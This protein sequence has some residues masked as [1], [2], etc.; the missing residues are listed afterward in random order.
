MKHFLIVLFLFPVTCFAQFKI[1]GRI[2][3]AADGKPIPDASVFINNT[4]TGAK[5]GADGSFTLNNLNAG[6]YDLIV[7]ALGYER[8]NSTVMVDKNIAIG[9]IKILPQTMMMNEVTITTKDP[10]RAL[11]IWT[12]KEQFLGKASFGFGGECELLNPNVLKLVFS[13]HRQVLTA[14][15][16]DFLEIDNNALGYNLKKNRERMRRKNAGKRIG[17]KFI[18]V[19]QHI[20]CEPSW[21]TRLM[22]ILWCGLFV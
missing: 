13:D 5:A 11:K 2:I 14:S 4:S 18:M 3:N 8:Y 1:T 6:Q 9:D 17:V 10:A 20:F 22:L 7:S 16:N 15:T 19:R 21:P 12:F